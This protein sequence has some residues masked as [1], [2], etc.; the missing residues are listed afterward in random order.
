MPRSRFARPALLL[1]LVLPALVVLVVLWSRWSS[2]EAADSSDAVPTGNASAAAATSNAGFTFPVAEA[3]A[4]SATSAET[5]ATETSL[6]EV[7]PEAA[8]DTEPDAAQARSIQQIEDAVVTYQASSLPVIAPFLVHGDPVVREAAREGVVQMGLSEAA[9]LLREA[10]GKL[11]D[12][13]EAILLLDAADFLEL[14]SVPS[15]G[16]GE[17]RILPGPPKRQ[18]GPHPDRSVPGKTTEPAS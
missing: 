6:A 7:P 5:P 16:K 15:L 1:G 10:A 8:S 9:P 4:P 3:P 17:K 2:A 12:P 13:R 11:K 14:P 18:S